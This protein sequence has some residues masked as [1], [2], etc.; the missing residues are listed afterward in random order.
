M[1][2]NLHLNDSTSDAHNDTRSTVI[3]DN[4]SEVTNKLISNID[5]NT[6]Q[7]KSDTDS[8]TNVNT[9]L[10]SGMTTDT[11]PHPETPGSHNFF[12][13]NVA[14][15]GELVTTP[16]LLKL[17]KHDLNWNSNI[18]YEL[19]LI[20]YNG[21]TNI[22]AYVLTH[23]TGLFVILIIQLTFLLLVYVF[24]SRLSASFSF[25]SSS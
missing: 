9:D 22:G 15:Q 6:N 23:L 2:S 13:P 17:F 4:K 14:E 25:L 21:L 24:K 20:Q 5:I 11:I 8:S 19:L 16:N 1:T 12:V 18:D 10:N 7:R 3:P